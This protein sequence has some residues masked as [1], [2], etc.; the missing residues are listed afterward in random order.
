[1]SAYLAVPAAIQFQDE[2][3]WPIVRERCH[4]LLVQAV[5]RICSL[6]GMR[7]IYQSDADYH[8]MAIAPLPPQDDLDWLKKRLLEEFR[9]EVP[10]I[11]WD[12]GHFIRISVQ[13]YNDQEDIDTLLEALGEIL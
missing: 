6:T 13:G 5:H 8:Q 7:S 3:N 11:E 10:L 4:A 2:N 1:M 12:D 9:I